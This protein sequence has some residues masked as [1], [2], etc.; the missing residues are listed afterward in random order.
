VSRFNI[1]PRR[2]AEGLAIGLILAM[3]LY[4]ARQDHARAECAPVTAAVPAPF[5][6]QALPPEVARE[7]ENARRNAYSREVN[8][9]LTERVISEGV[10]LGMQ[11]ARIDVQGAKQ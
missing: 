8:R 1:N 2:A 10:A 3:A 6:A 11:Q 7:Y 4:I 5:D 9:L